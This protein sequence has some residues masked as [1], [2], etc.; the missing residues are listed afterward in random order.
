MD[1]VATQGPLLG[2]AE[3]PDSSR[4]CDSQAGWKLRKGH[5]GPTDVNWKTDDEFEVESPK[6]AS[7]G[8]RQSLRLPWFAGKCLL[9]R[10]Q[11]VEHLGRQRT[12]LDRGERILELLRRRHT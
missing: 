10:C 3:L 2:L 1:A 9:Q 7:V 4:R 5:L 8:D 11:P 12:F 6:S